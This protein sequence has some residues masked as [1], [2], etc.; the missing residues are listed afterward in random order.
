ML[1]SPKDEG[2]KPVRYEL[3]QGDFAVIPA[4]T[5]YQAANESDDEDLH[6]IIIRSGPEPIEV[7]LADWGGSE[8]KDAPTEKHA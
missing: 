2:E 5:E 3:E 4:W 8:L 7:N 1:S 6:W